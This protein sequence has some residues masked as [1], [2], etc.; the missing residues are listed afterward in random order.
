LTG[1]NNEIDG[2]FS[3]TP[4]I[5]HLR[6]N[7]YLV[8]F[9]TTDNFF[10]FDETVQFEVTYN[11]SINE[12]QNNLFV[13]TI[14]PN[15]ARNS[16]T[17]PILIEKNNNIKIDIYNNLGIKVSSRNLELS[18]GSHLIV[19]NFNLNN[20]QYFVNITDEFG[21]IKTTKKLLILK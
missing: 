2:V 13:Q 12:D 14:Y 16:F 11:T 3:W 5:N 9:R 21:T 7:P 20:G 1:N 6:E 19:N 17:L 8:V 10:Y 18:A 15:P 4:D